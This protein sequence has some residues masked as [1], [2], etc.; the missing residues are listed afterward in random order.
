M[1]GIFGVNSS[2]TCYRIILIIAEL[3]HGK[4]MAIQRL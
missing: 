3:F 2:R 1:L 4:T